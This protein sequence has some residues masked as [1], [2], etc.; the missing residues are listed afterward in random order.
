MRHVLSGEILYVPLTQTFYILNRDLKSIEVE[1]GN[2]IEGHIKQN[3]GPLEE[4]V[5]SVSCD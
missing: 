4:R 2:C 3:E 1:S 5:G